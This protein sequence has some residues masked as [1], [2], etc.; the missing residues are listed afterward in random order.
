MTD[1]NYDLCVRLRLRG[2]IPSSR[3]HHTD[4]CAIDLGFVVQTI[5]HYNFA[6]DKLHTHF[7]GW[8]F[9]IFLLQNLYSQYL[10]WRSQILQPKQS[11]VKYSLHLNGNKANRKPGD[12]GCIDN[13][14]AQHHNSYRLTRGQNVRPYSTSNWSVGYLCNLLTRYEHRNNC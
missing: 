10:C 9:L 5:V 4:P 12:A 3:P 2:S 11:V 14:I 13:T 7:C 1:S 8:E 6:P